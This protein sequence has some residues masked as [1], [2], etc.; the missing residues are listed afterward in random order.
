[1]FRAH[2]TSTGTD[3]VANVLPEEFKLLQ[4]YPNPFNPSTS[5]KYALPFES[6]VKL[7]VYNTVGEKVRELVSSVQNSG[8][9]EVIFKADDLP[10]G[11]YFYSIG[12]TSVSGKHHNIVSK[13]MLLLK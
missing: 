13:K 3:E 7:V 9:H 8:Y 5:I 12:A 11:I 6:Y 2:F 10:S 1:D 4:N